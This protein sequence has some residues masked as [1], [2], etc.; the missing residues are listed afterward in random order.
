LTSWTGYRWL[1]HHQERDTRSQA[2]CRKDHLLRR[3]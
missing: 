2:L 3:V 1:A